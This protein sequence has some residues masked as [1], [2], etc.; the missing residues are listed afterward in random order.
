MLKFA[1]SVK[2]PLIRNDQ[3]VLFDENILRLYNVIIDHQTRSMRLNYFRGI[4][5][6]NSFFQVTNNQILSVD[7]MEPYF[8]MAMNPTASESSAWVTDFNTYKVE[9]LI[10]EQNLIQGL[11]ITE[12]IEQR[13]TGTKRVITPW[14]FRKRFTFTERMAIEAHSDAGVKTILGDLY[15]VQDVDLD[16]NSTLLSLQ[17]LASL[18]LITAERIQEIL[19]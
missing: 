1:E 2:V 8:S 11:T 3:P 7:I 16:D 10:K 19:A 9:S 13:L 18:E 12:I 14:E 15:T 17:Y 5:D 6:D 4:I